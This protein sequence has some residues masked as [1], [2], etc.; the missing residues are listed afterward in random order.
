MARADDL[1][2]R[3][4]ETGSGDEMYAQ[5]ESLY[6]ICRS[7]TGDGVRQ[8]L[9]EV[10]GA[11]PLDIH[12]VPSGT[13][14]FDWT[15]PREWNIRDAWI[16]DPAGNKVV[17]FQAHNLH[18]VNYSS[19]INETMPLESLKAHLHSLPDH[20][21]WIPYRTSYYSESWGFCLPHRVLEDLQEGDYQVLID[22]T[23]EDG[24]LSYGECLIEG[25][26]TDE[27]LLSAHVCHPSLAN[28]NLSGIALLTRLGKALRSVETRYSYRLIFAPGTIGS[29]TW[30]ARNQEQAKH[31]RHGLV[32]SC[33][34]DGGGP[35][36]KKSRI[37]N[38][39][40]D[41]AMCQVL[42]DVAPEASIEEF[43]P[44]GY[45]E[46]QYCSPGFNLPVGLFERSKYGAFPEY[47]TSADNLDF[48]SAEELDRSYEIVC[49]VIDI[50]ETH[51]T[52][53]NKLSFCEPQLG[54]RGLYEAM[55]GDNQRVE[56][57]MA[58]LWVLNLADGEHSLLD[59]AERSGVAYSLIKETADI[60]IDEGLLED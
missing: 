35:M 1:L 25:Q 45:D 58:M 48:I 29:I 8:T 39:R 52:P 27:V 42:A 4:L 6:P 12:E 21:D 19:P 26:T 16:R 33:V 41:R 32:V 38:A 43:S 34:G 20:P 59:M 57:Q 11:I 50:L 14:V 17:D 22:S 37:G 7:I 49:R 2:K 13:E 46:R 18:V 56:R 60:L 30:L 28:D 31:I 55:G 47:H 9:R 5:A 36:Y 10:S 3:L 15:V 54:K 24:S 40:I 51:R 23:L 53:V 44:Y